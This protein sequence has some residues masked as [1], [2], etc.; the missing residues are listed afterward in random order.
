MII[1]I[2]KLNYY[3]VYILI[4]YRMNFCKK[5]NFSLN[6]TKKQL[7]EDEK[8][9]YK[10]ST[11]EAFLN[12]VKFNITEANQTID[13]KIDRE[14]LKEKLSSKLKKNPEKVEEL[15]RL[16]DVTSSK[17]NNFDVYLICTN[18][19]SSYTINPKTKILTTNLEGTSSQFK[20]LNLEY[21]CRDPTIPRT[22]DYICHNEKCTTHKDLENKEAV[23]F[24]QGSGYNISYICCICNTMWAI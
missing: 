5:C 22:K 2:D 20:E 4:L 8:N 24:R 1:K 6:I 14:S 3:K 18:C 23:F 7:N 9:H 13:M 16:Y 15:M 17:K 12:Y 19:N 11:V 10:I 21:K